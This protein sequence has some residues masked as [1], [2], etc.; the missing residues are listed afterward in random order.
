M[1]DLPSPRRLG[2]TYVLDERIGAGAQGEVWRGRRTASAESGGGYAA[3]G[4][5]EVLAFKLLRADL[6][7]DVG[8]VDRFIKE[9][10]TL[11]RVRS[12]YVVAIRDVVIEGSTFA[13]AMD[14]VSGGDLKDLLREHGPL[15]PAEVARVGADVAAGLAAVHGA[16]VVHRDVKPANI[17]M[18][19]AT[20]PPTPRVADFGVAR[21]SDTVA[22]GHVTGIMGTPLYM[23]PEI[24]SAQVPSAAADI[25]SLGVVLYEASCGTPPFTGTP[26]QL[27][28]QHARRA[29]GRPDGVPDPLWDLVTA[30]LAKQPAVRPS[31]QDVAAR[32]QA[33]R[34]ALDNLPAAP[35]LASAPATTPSAAP[36][37]WGED[38]A[39]TWA[40]SS[41]TAG[42]PPSTPAGPTGYGTSHSARNAD[43]AKAPR[44]APTVGYGTVPTRVVGAV[45]Y[46]TSSAGSGAAPPSG[47]SPA[48]LGYTRVAPSSPSASPSAP[49]GAYG[50]AG[51]PPP[52]RRR[53]TWVVAVVVIAV[54]VLVAGGAGVVG[55]LLHGRED[56]GS[57]VAALPAGSSVSEGWRLSDTS[58]V[59]VSPDSHLLA[60]ESSSTW[61]LYDLTASDHSAVW[62]GSC[63]TQGFW[64]TDRF[65]C[66][67]S[68]T[69]VLVDA[70]GTTTTPPG[71][72]DHNLQGTTAQAA[73]LIDDSYQGDLVG[74]DAAGDET[75]RVYG[76]YDRAAVS[77]GFVLAYEADSEQLQVLS[78]ATATVLV[79]VPMDSSDIDW[80]E[81]LPGG[82][83]INVGSGAFYRVD[84]ST[85]TVYDAS[86]QEKATVGTGTGTGSWVASAPTDAG[87]LE[88]LVSAAAQAG[89]ATVVRGRDRTVT[90][91]TDLGACTAT[92]DG[93]ALNLPERADGEDCVITPLGLTADDSAV[94]VGTGTYS[95]SS[96]DTGDV[97]AA[98]SL[99]DGARTWEVKG[100]WVAALDG[101][102]F[103]VRQKGEYGDLVVA[104]VVAR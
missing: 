19:S 37:V 82:F 30:M 14:Y 20:S 21:I 87:A 13:I 102:R 99:K 27:L 94:L 62:S 78:A 16:G 41:T 50:L 74:L 60:V 91:T 17:L 24:L 59:L 55:R 89:G 8:V 79:S 4:V 85:T 46:G 26:A 93:V 57:W 7:E 66:A 65:L 23:A 33:M 56:P 96:S 12:P 44:T 38:P 6:V 53:R 36:Y 9:R 3:P 77:D 98:Y 80:D 31:A 39:E 61:S 95:Y 100:T 51:Q 10:S 2:S 72:K 40:P 73:V 86:G 28:G 1:S 103:L 81:A 71:P 64:T 104:S 69:A 32:L 67:T 34:P 29:P 15:T 76:S 43:V 68:D 63:Y 101:G 54:L 11:L 58:S 42:V 88:D 70:T 97:V 18:D 22:S 92:V 5:D 49:T 47:T 83:G 90:V 52:A 75:W 48:T 84:G 25:Y 35:R 45:G